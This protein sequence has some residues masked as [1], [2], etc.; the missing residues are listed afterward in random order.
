MKS[1]SEKQRRTEGRTTQ[2]DRRDKK[3]F[4]EGGSDR[5]HG[6]SMVES[7]RNI[8]TKRSGL[9]GLGKY[10]LRDNPRTW[11]RSKHRYM[12]HA[13][14]SSQKSTRISEVIEWEIKRRKLRHKT[15]LVI[16]DRDGYNMFLRQEPRFRP[17]KKNIKTNHLMIPSSL[18]VLETQT[19]TTPNADTKKHTH[20]CRKGPSCSNIGAPFP[21]HIRNWA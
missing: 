7:R 2:K 3:L 12:H 17:G 1:E 21:H 20:T 8:K 18:D 14:F 19:D 11:G 9:F 10:L 15:N 16:R 4:C 13:W 6:M 5:R